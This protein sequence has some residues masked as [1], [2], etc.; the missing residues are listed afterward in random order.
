[1]SIKKNSKFSRILL[2][3]SL[4][5]AQ[6]SVAPTAAHAGVATSFGNGTYTVGKNIAPGIYR[7]K[8]AISLKGDCY[9]EIS[10]T[11]SNGNDII[12]NDNSPGGVITFNLSRGQ[13]I[14]NNCGTFVKTTL[15]AKRGTPKTSFGNGVWLVG[16]DIAPGTYVTQKD[17]LGGRCYLEISTAGS[18]GEDIIDNGNY[19]KGKPSATLDAGTEFKNAGCGLMK[20]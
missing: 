19:A 5:V 4:L 8:T 14:E 13:D 12:S 16:I 17:V 7:S 20:K 2:V 10:T 3:G 9:W 18:N 15:T 6:S 1:M 11:G